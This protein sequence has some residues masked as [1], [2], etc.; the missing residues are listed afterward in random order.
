MGKS[1]DFEA[2]LTQ[3]CEDV[4]ARANKDLQRAIGHL[5][6]LLVSILRDER[7]N[8]LSKADL[9]ALAE[10]IKS[11]REA[12]TQL[13]AAVYVQDRVLLAQNSAVLDVRLSHG[14]LRRAQEEINEAFETKAVPKRGFVYVAWRKTPERFVYVGKANSVDRL[15]LATH[16]K[17]A[18]AATGDATLL[19]LLFPTQSR[20]EILFDVEASVIELVRSCT[21]EK[22]QYN[23]KNEKV[24]QGS[25]SKRL[26]DLAAF[27]DSIA[28]GL[29]RNLVPK[30]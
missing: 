11:S 10:A 24:P 12:A 14:D 6:K 22:P 23:E 25:G 28:T 21:G 7:W 16:G 29:D 3:I 30:K 8:E 9:R 5:A 27:L 13:D 18:M 17:L 26:V 20:E 1:G 4:E 2:K 19:S 15:N